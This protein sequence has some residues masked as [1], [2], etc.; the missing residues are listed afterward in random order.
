MATG[1]GTIHWGD[2][3]EA[4]CKSGKCVDNGKLEGKVTMID[5]T[6]ID[7]VKYVG[8]FQNDQKNGKGKLTIT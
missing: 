3:K 2:L 7:V 4:T 1:K 8:P 5:R 6:D